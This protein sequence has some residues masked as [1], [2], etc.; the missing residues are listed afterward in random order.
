MATSPNTILEKIFM[1]ELG[2]TGCEHKDPRNIGGIIP[3]R[4]IDPSNPD[5]ETRL[6]DLYSL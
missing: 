5:F 3:K 2:F 1:H 4:D 6:Q